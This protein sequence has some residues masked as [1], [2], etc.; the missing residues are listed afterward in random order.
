MPGGN[1]FLERAETLALTRST[2]AGT[3]TVPVGEGPVARLAEARAAI[4]RRDGASAATLIAEAASLGRAQ[5]LRRCLRGAPEPPPPRAAPPPWRS[6][7][8]PPPPRRGPPCAAD[9][10]F[11][12]APAS[13]T[14]YVCAATIRPT[15]GLTARPRGAQGCG[16]PCGGARTGADILRRAR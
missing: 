5:G 15:I 9:E 12:L 7:A 13:L 11:F 8:I 4:A 14:L 10:A 1:E 6:A 16:R 2:L 3:E